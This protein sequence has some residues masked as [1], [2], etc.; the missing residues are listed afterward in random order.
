MIARKT[1]LTTLLLERSFSDKMT[2]WIDDFSNDLSNGSEPRFAI[3]RPDLSVNNIFVDEESNSSCGIDWVFCSIVPL[4]TL[5][6]APGLPHSWYELD[7]PLLSMF[8]LGFQHGLKENTAP[9]DIGTS[10][11]LCKF[12][13]PKPSNVALFLYSDF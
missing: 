12:L 11:D 1:G 6:T 10:S 7:V 4:S 3:H 9:H 13:K 5:L 2:N 8:E